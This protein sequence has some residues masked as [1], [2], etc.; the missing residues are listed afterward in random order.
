MKFRNVLFFFIIIA[1]ITIHNIQPEDNNEA[2]LSESL[3]NQLEQLDI[4]IE[5]TVRNRDIAL[6][7]PK[8]SI[9]TRTQA[10]SGT[11]D[12]G[13]IAKIIG[14]V[15]YIIENAP[16]LQRWSRLHS[17][18]LFKTVFTF[19]LKA[20]ESI[21]N[22]K[23]KPT[24][25]LVSIMNVTLS[26]LLEKEKESLLKKAL[27]VDNVWQVMTL[28]TKY[29]N[30]TLVRTEKN[31]IKIIEQLKFNTKQVQN[32]KLIDITENPSEFISLQTD[33]I[34]NE[35]DIVAIAQIIAEVVY[36]LGSDTE[37]PAKEITHEFIQAADKAIENLKSKKQ[38]NLSHLLMQ[39]LI[40]ACNKSGYIRKDLVE[41]A[42]KYNCLKQIDVLETEVVQEDLEEL[43]ATDEEKESIHK[44]RALVQKI[45]KIQQEFWPGIVP[46]GTI[47]KSASEI[48]EKQ[49]LDELLVNNNHW[50]GEGV[51]KF[52]DAIYKIIDDY[53]I[54][55]INSITI[56]GFGLSDLDDFFKAITK[57]IHLRS[58]KFVDLYL[59]YHQNYY[60]IDHETTLLNALSFQA[61]E[62]K[63]S[64]TINNSPNLTYAIGEKIF[65]AQPNELMLPI[66]LTKIVDLIIIDNK[67]RYMGGAFKRRGLESIL[68]NINKFVNLETVKILNPSNPGEYNNDLLKTCDKI[69]NKWLWKQERK[70]TVILDN[71]VEKTFEAFSVRKAREREERLKIANPVIKNLEEQKEIIQKQFKTK[72]PDQNALARA[73]AL[74]KQSITTIKSLEGLK[75]EKTKITK[76]LENIIATAYNIIFNKLTTREAKTNPTKALFVLLRTLADNDALKSITMGGKIAKTKKKMNAK[77][78]SG[79]LT[80]FTITVGPKLQV[81]I[82]LSK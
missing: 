48:I 49:R 58:L 33:T 67:K 78:K 68:R 12:E 52:G 37:E 79:S 75:Q 8:R 18:R 35:K 38:K 30:E 62:G 64:L 24:K 66:F 22:L 74:T 56:K 20:N 40:L 46:E 54:K 4:T 73:I 32:K 2:P 43:Y 26:M 76:L 9:V 1:A 60:Y 70:L 59:G 10:L 21:K 77:K 82:D 72:S 25:K 39:D 65:Q 27:S 57:K 17:K 31:N 51:R 28:Q 53:N 29:Y 15:A 23:N 42:I 81:T 13:K 36:I 47:E 34:K 61:I 11:Q 6:Q 55:T 69:Y 41:F 19:L 14:E 71:N 16:A 63:G 50:S 45:I 5:K 80:I 3:E 7:N 44:K